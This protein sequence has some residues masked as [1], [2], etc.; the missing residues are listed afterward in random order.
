MT[1]RLTIFSGN[2][3]CIPGHILAAWAP[4]TDPPNHLDHT[5]DW[6][7]MTGIGQGS[8]DRTNGINIP[9]PST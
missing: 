4:S 5:I 6:V 8:H 2:P 7:R 9:V 3:K 1:G